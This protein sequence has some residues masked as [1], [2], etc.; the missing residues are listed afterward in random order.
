MSRPH[1]EI[2]CRKQ[3]RGELIVFS[4]SYKCFI[5]S[6]ISISSFDSGSVA[7]SLRRYL[8]PDST[9]DL[10]TFVPMEQPDSLTKMLSFLYSYLNLV[11]YFRS[12]GLPKFQ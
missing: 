7:S 1:D 6:S 8:W 3:G 2:K 4:V 5:I 9:E 10:Q 12:F 11:G